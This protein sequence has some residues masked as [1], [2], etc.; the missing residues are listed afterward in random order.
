M[1]APLAAETCIMPAPHEAPAHAFHHPKWG[2][3]SAIYVYRDRNGAVLGYICRFETEDGKQILP[4][5]YWHTA[6]GA[7][8][9]W[10]GF[11]EP[12]PLYGLDKLA[13]YPNRPI[14]ICEGEKAADA[15][16]QLIPDHVCITSP[17]GSNAA[18]KADWSPVK[19]RKVYIWPDCDEPGRKY[20][21]SVARILSQHNQVRI[22]TPPVDKPAGWDAADALAEG[23]DRT[24]VE[25]LI[26]E[27]KHYTP[28]TDTMDTMTAASALSADESW[29]EPKPIRHQLLPVE[30]FPIAILPEAFQPWIG[31]LAHRLQCPPDIAACAAITMT[32]AIIGAGCGIRPKRRDDWLVIPNLFGAAV[33][34][35]S[36]LLK[37]P[38]IQESFKPM[39]RLE[40][41]ALEEYEKLRAY[42]EADNEMSKAERDGIRKEMSQ[43]VKKR[44]IDSDA[45]EMLKHKYANMEEPEEPTLRRYRTNDS[46]PEKLSELLN[47]NPRGILVFR[48][49]LTALIS[50]WEKEGREMERGF[51]LEAWNGK[52]SY[53]CDRIGRGTT[54]TP[55]M[56][57]SI[58]GGIQPDKLLT[59]LNECRKSNDGMFQRFQMLV[60][61]DEPKNWTLVDNYPDTEAKNHAYDIIKN[62]SNMDFAAAG[63]EVKENDS[64]PFFRYDPDA[65]ELFYEWLTQLE[66]EKLRGTAM[67]PMLAEHLGKFRKLMPSLSLI[68]HLIDVAS[69]KETDPAVSLEATERAAAWCEYLESHARRV[70]GLVES[71]PIKAATILAARVKKNALG[72]RFTA[73]DVYRHQWSFLTD[74]DAAQAACEI[75]VD[76]GWLREM[77]TEPS[78]GQRGKTEY[79]VNPKLQDSGN[80]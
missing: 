13:A 48:D 63:A 16:Q 26:A 33:A 56:C 55:N 34:R 50:G 28:S 65:Q 62:L 73:R 9:R 32:G 4:L 68:F 72:N 23:W 41:E 69:G 51:Y 11:P 2:K 60:Y 1:T 44:S 29:P 70:Y 37:S 52:Q 57:V 59:Y 42:Y 14:I 5:T 27:S 6:Q 22:I 39:I 76:A 46:T 75:L 17:G 43:L 7:G 61:P 67:E 40:I 71:M 30:P 64:T 10:K 74:K 45:K 80:E 36:V 19:D 49:E 47:E 66:V 58:F 78:F 3:P 20:A 77:V 54:Y 31:D 18:H 21:D 35:P 8:W 38:T 53:F 79:I 15:A 12:R 24:P 25:K